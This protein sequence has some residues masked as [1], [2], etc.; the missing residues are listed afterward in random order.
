MDWIWIVEH[1]QWPKERVNVL[2]SVVM[3]T[4]TT[5]EKAMDLMRLPGQGNEG[6]FV[7][8]PSPLDTDDVC[9][10]PD[11]KYYGEA[12]RIFLVFDI[13][14]KPLDQQPDRYIH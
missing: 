3:Y 4:T 11:P 13:Q 8:Y 7:I 10:M 5:L 1:R 6:W 9:A 12:H 2:D 14:G